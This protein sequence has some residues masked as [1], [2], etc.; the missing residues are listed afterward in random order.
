ML[1][2]F[3]LR[4]K[5]LLLKIDKIL[6]SI[7]SRLPRILRITKTSI[8]TTSLCII[9][10]TGIVFA[11]TEEDAEKS[12]L[13]VWVNN[14]VPATV[15]TASEIIGG[16]VEGV[17]EPTGYLYEVD[18]G[19]IT[20]V[21]NAMVTTYSEAND[22]L[23]ASK[24]ITETLEEAD[25]IDDVYAA[26][27]GYATFQPVKNLWNFT[28]NIS[29]TLIIGVAAILTVMILLRLRQGQGYISILTALPRL[30]V[31]IVLILV[32]F[33]LSGLLMD[34]ANVLQNFTLWMFHTDEFLDY[35]AYTKDREDKGGGRRAYT[36]DQGNPLYPKNPYFGNGEDNVGDFNVFRLM[37]NFT[38]FENWGY[39]DCKKGE[40][41]LTSGEG[42]GYCPINGPAD[43]IRT[44]TSMGILDRG[45]QMTSGVAADE[46]L[47]L[48]I[49]IVIITAALKIFFA[50][51]KGLVKVS[52]GT[53][54]APLVFLTIPIKGMNGFLGWLRLMLS[55]VLIFPLTF[56]V[57]FL[58]AIIV[59]YTKAPWFTIE[60]GQPLF[61]S[62]PDLLLYTAVTKNGEPVFLQKIVGLAIVMG[63]P[64]LPQ[65]LD[66]ALRQ[67]ENLF[68]RNA[69]NALRSV[70]GKFPII[71]GFFR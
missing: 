12:N 9:F 32:S 68:E 54:A 43:I 27:P 46:T 22:N 14:L 26:S 5:L 59:G 31:T 37:A 6:L 61:G 23:S 17:A 50:L 19:L 58:A 57:L 55:G 65:M 2:V 3:F 18:G 1:R 25:I 70:G 52:L 41:K 4:I 44:P 69:S 24:Y 16:K 62:A 11:Q 8:I 63:I 21:N 30:A 47:K 67:T 60:S 48:I 40:A 15:R 39:R 34:L 71:G 66:Q 38:E 7:N 36:D 10:S 53:I 29:L 20:Y 28:K 51:V 49:K 42:Q 33:S 35:E 64:A 13:E 56:L 45:I